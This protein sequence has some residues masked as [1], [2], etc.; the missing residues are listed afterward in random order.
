MATFIA[1]GTFDSPQEAAKA[2][3]RERDTFYPSAENHR[4]YDKLYKNVYLKMYPSL[5][6]SYEFLWDFAK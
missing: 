3:V 1:L 6:A 2:M 4:I 5:K